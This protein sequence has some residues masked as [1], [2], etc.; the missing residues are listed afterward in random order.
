VP[1]WKDVHAAIEK[2]LS[3]PD[4]LRSELNF[5]SRSGNQGGEVE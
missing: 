5:L 1:I 3:D 2:T 4:H